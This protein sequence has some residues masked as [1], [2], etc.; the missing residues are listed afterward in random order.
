MRLAIDV[1]S[2][3]EG[4]HSGVEEYTTQ[5]IT[6]LKRYAPG[7][8]YIL[9][10]NAARPV[11]LPLALRG[12]R[13][14][15]LRYPNKAFNAAQASL[16]WPKW[17]RFVQADCFFVPSL[18]LLPVASNIPVVTTV[19]D[20][21]FERF[22]EFFSW[23]RR[24]WHQLM[25]PRLLMENSDQLIA[26]SQ[27]TA[28][29][30]IDVYGIAR[31]KIS[32]IH[33]GISPRPLAQRN[34]RTFVRQKYQLPPAYLLYFGTLEP[35]KNI[36]SIIKAYSAIADQISQHLVIAG[37]RGWLTKE[38]D[39]AIAQS[40]V[41]DR[42]HVIGFI[43]EADKWSLYTG[44]DL[45]VYPSFYEGF[46]FPPLEALVSGTPVVTSHNTALPEIV[47]KWATLVDPY[48]PGE[49][50]GVMRELLH[51]PARV[52]AATQQEILTEYSWASAATK[53]IEVIESVC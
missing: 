31:E 8:E 38:L 41:A 20:L 48:Q 30:L 46:G 26:V 24:R 25:Q 44:A 40:Q 17:N 3:M 47:G 36:I 7:H 14:V 43:E 42:I 16:R 19:H 13:T 53:T 12:F 52:S 29:D 9:F 32:V 1:R 4:R 15:A 34:S 18:R 49:L 33:S 23:W 27:A 6:A 45:F 39:A 11:R 2:L 22:P 51:E 50:A 10:Y 37:A 21:S 5:I 28:R 35:R